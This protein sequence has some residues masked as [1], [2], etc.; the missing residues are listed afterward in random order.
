L[1]GAPAFLDANLREDVAEL[2]Q[3][4][5]SDRVFPGAVAAVASASDQ[6]FIAAGRE[7]YDA[8]SPRVETR[9]LFDVASLTKVVATTTAIMQVID[10][11]LVA[12]DDPVARYLRRFGE[13]ERKDITIRQ[14]LTHTA[15]FPGPYEFFRFCA[16]RNALIE[17]IYS[18]ALTCEPGT[19]RLYDD[20]GF[21]LLA[22]IVEQV[23][24]ESFD[25]Y[26]AQHIFKP[27][28]M[29]D[30]LFRPQAFKGQIIPTEIDPERGGLLRGIVHDENA[31]VLGGV[32]G[33]AGLFSTAA[34][35]V[36]FARMMLRANDQTTVLSEAS[37]Q[38]VREREWR[39]GEGEYGLGWDKIRPLYMGALADEETIGHTG[40]T[41]TSLVISPSRGLAIILLSNRIYPK[42]SDPAPI[43]AVRRRLA[44]IVLQ[45]SG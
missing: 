28:R 29:A 25:Q 6:I 24:G 15:G 34:D 11:G 2:L 5:I 36:R 23:M 43:H 22:L 39:D 40:F 38:R 14:L 42:R 26:C 45:R 1:E 41:G 4:A 9:A 8:S 21:I 32:A 30:T 10:N 18:V 7:T 3:T 31:Y 16:T 12:L 44:E 37:I 33:H 27:L 20:I 35:F 13:D 17:A 19:A